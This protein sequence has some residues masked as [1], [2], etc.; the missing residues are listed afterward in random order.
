MSIEI[1]TTRRRLKPDAVRLHRRIQADE[2]LPLNSLSRANAG[3]CR[4]SCPKEE[5]PGRGIGKATGESN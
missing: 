5:G 4:P 3:E 2:T 1:G